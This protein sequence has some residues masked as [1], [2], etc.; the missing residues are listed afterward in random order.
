LMSDISTIMSR[1]LSDLAEGNWA[2]IVGV[3]TED[4]TNAERLADLGFRVGQQVKIIARGGVGG[5]LAVRV[6]GS[7]FALRLTEAAEILVA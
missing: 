4:P 2:T 3:T 1:R 5:P 6:Q 7:T